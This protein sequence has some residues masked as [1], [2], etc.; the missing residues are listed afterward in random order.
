MDELR[1]DD[2]VVVVTGAARGIGRSYALEFARRGAQVVA[3]DYGADLDGSGA[4]NGPVEEVA[5]EIRAA[6]GEAVACFA[7]V[8]EEDDAA[9]IVG[10]AIRTF[11]RL[12][13]VVNNA[14]ISDP[15]LF[16]ELSTQQFARMLD[17]HLFGSVFVC[18]AAWPCFVEAGY[19]RI[20]NTVS[21]AML[22]GIEQLTSYGAAKGAVFGLTRN[23]ATEGA[24]A[25]IHANAVAPRAATRMS[26]ADA[27]RLAEVFGFDDQALA[28]V[29]ASMPPEQCSP[30]VVYLAHES[31]LL[32]G[33]VLQVGMGG[34]TRLA[35]VQTQGLTKETLTAEDVA[36]NIEAILAL[37]DANVTSAGS[38]G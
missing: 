37:A 24:A 1:F 19:G 34:V 28:D 35:V 4:S 18:R 14:G 33:E 9:S 21:E 31:C 22:G 6:G 30:G 13:V 32:N 27:D 10:T 3:A 11:G 2:R 5:A 20:V 16:G 7:S 26:K 36:E 38:M 23:L 12:D 15:A 17:V 8:A 29:M 25:G